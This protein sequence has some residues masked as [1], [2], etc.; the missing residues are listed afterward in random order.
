MFNI[1]LDLLPTEYKGFPIDSDFQI[2]IQIMQALE[3]EELTQQEQIETALSLLFLHKDK[4]GNPLSLPDVQTAVDG[5]MWFLFGWNHDNNLKSGGEKV[6]DWYID[7]WRIYS[8]FR[9]QYG[10]NLNDLGMHCV[11]YKISNNKKIYPIYKENKLHF[12]EFMALLTTLPDDC[13]YARIA[14]IRAKKITSKMSKEERETYEKL[15]N[16][17]SLKQSKIVKYNDDQKKAIDEYDRM[18]EEQRKIRKKNLAKK[19]FEEMI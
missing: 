5:L 13:S 10:I 3:D 11:G 14:D 15:K 8:A 7:Q 19:A 1:L 16:I 2:G 9:Q 17:Y 4:E 6:T 12:W 18:M